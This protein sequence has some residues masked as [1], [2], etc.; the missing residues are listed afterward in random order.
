MCVS[1]VSLYIINIIYGKR[2]CTNK[3]FL[4]TV[5]NVFGDKVI[6][7]DECA[8]YLPKKILSKNVDMF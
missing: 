6:C 8:E 5:K 1:T 3:E 4:D 2:N 7:Y